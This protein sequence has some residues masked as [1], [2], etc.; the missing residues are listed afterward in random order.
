MVRKWR[1]KSDIEAIKSVAISFLY[2]DVEETEFS[3]IVDHI[4]YL[5][6]LLFV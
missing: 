2:Y 5:K 3:P 6:V 1:M 4:L